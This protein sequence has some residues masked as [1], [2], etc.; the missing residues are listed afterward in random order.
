[1]TDKISG[2]VSFANTTS[3]LNDM[4]HRDEDK[5]F[6]SRTIADTVG[7]DGEDKEQ[8]DIHFTSRI[9]E[10]TAWLDKEGKVIP[11][12]EIHHLQLPLLSILNRDGN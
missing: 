11:S 10:E 2:L 1:M 8:N 6:A 12:M 3:I 5:M 4:L 9:F 7:Q